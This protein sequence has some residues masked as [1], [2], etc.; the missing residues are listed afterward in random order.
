MIKIKQTVIVEG[1][2]DKIK[3]SSF[4]D[5]LIIET[6][7]FKIFK[8]KQK[9]EMI[10]KL[11]NKNGLV[12]FTDSDR[13]GFKI[14]A[15]IKSFCDCEDVYHAYIPDINGKEK[16]KNLP[17]KEG[18]IGLEGMTKEVILN[19]LERAGVL[20]EEDFKAE[21]ERPIT[22]V[23]LFNDGLSGQRNSKQKKNKLLKHLD[24]PSALSTKSFLQIINLFLTYDK[25]KETLNY[26]G[27][28]HTEA[29]D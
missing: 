15:F 17:S 1:K 29:G 20:F 25:Y 21:P 7:G 4:L 6:D 8:N 13:A 9:Q 11:A 12:I 24:L 27:L 14:R 5:A 26:L 28:T 22:I 23:D 2:Y 19:A 10:R 16:R 3:L 18:K